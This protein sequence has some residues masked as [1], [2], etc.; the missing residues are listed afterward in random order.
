MR[1]FDFTEIRELD[2]VRKEL[3]TFHLHVNQ[4]P[5][6]HENLQTRGTTRLSHS[7]ETE[8]G[9]ETLFWNH[10]IQMRLY[11]M[12]PENQTQKIGLPQMEIANKGFCRSF[13]YWKLNPFS[14]SVIPSSVVA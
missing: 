3:L 2:S 14:C 1:N 9:H 7:A 12:I 8:S 13:F 5:D 4:S 11:A 10:S 6:S